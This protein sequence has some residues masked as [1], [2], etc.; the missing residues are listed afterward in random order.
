VRNHLVCSIVAMA[1]LLAVSCANPSSKAEP[2][3]T[4]NGRVPDLSGVWR[5]IKFHPKMY[6]DGDTPFTPWAAA[7]FK[8]ADSTKNDPRLDCLPHGM[9]MFMFSVQ[10]F[11]I[12]Q[13]PNRL[14]MHLED[15]S[16][17]REIYIDGRQHPPDP[18]ASYN[19]HSVGRWE[20]DTLVV[21]TIA[22]KEK[23]WLDHVG[24][25]HSDVLHVVERIRR[26][27]H[28]S[29]VNDVTVDDP[30]AFTKTWTSQQT[31]VLKPDWEIVENVCEENNKYRA[32]SPQLP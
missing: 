10:P 14:I 11:E 16:V 26:V 12:I 3:G 25:P 5:V 4:A 17:L 24:T 23:T 13:L 22:L 21:D 7:K 28:D 1:V 30:K 32:R 27:A 29:L 31:Y 15:D 18:D 20:G 19:G 8:T 2:P 6:Q 9:P